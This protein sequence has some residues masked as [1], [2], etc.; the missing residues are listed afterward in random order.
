[1]RLLGEL[2]CRAKVILTTLLILGLG[3]SFVA[4]LITARTNSN[5]HQS[6]EDLSALVTTYYKGVLQNRSGETANDISL[7][8]FFVSDALIAH[9]RKLEDDSD[10]ISYDP[11]ICAQDVPKNSAD[12]SVDLIA[13]T[14]SSAEI[15]VVL[16]RG[17]GTIIVSLVHEKDWKINSITCPL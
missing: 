8:P 17:W 14:D 12:L 9:F 16:A 6:S 13:S 11:F 7:D 15:S 1:M 4:L 10:G 3:T 5:I 2:N